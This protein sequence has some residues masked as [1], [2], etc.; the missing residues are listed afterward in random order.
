[1]KSDENEKSEDAEEILREMDESLAQMEKWR[2][3]NAEDEE[4]LQSILNRER[5]SRKEYDEPVLDL[6]EKQEIAV[7][8]EALKF[9]MRPDAFNTEDIL[10]APAKPITGSTGGPDM[11]NRDLSDISYK[12]AE[13]LASDPAAESD[14]PAETVDLKSQLEDIEKQLAELEAECDGVTLTNDY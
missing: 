8:K 11:S 7:N 1:M 6:P 4:M 14:K 9:E 13:S 3:K 2:K 5:P 10:K 12:I